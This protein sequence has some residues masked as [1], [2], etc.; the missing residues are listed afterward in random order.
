MIVSIGCSNTKVKNIELNCINITNDSTLR[1]RIKSNIDL[2]KFL[3][4]TEFQTIFFFAP[5]NKNDSFFI[6]RKFGKTEK[7]NHLKYLEFN[8][9]NTNILESIIDSNANVYETN[10]ILYNGYDILPVDSASTIIEDYFK[11]NNSITFKGYWTPYFLKGLN[12]AT[13]MN[14]FLVLESQLNLSSKKKR[15]N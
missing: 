4:T 14:N 8:I 9:S 10:L 13:D 3:N 7:L 12:K 15:N 11:K 5:I 2:K 1:I 6:W